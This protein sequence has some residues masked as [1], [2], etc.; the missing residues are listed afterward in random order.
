MF[1]VYR[2]PGTAPSHCSL[3]FGKKANQP[4]SK[5][6]PNVFCLYFRVDSLTKIV[7]NGAKGLH[8]TELCFNMQR[9]NTKEDA[10]SC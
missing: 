10:E 1:W 4:I 5:H 9:K 3:V 7:K 2:G 6:L 8:W